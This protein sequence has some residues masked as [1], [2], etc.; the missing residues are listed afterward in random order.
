MIPDEVDVIVCGG[1]STGC[2]VAG[3]LA[4]ASPDLQILIVEA[5]ANNYDSPWGYRVSEAR[6]LKRELDLC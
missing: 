6:A 5:G 3:R 4:R 2:C 1:G